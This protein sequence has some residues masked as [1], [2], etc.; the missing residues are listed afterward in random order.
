MNNQEE[1]MDFEEMELGPEKIQELF[2]DVGP[3]VVYD[4]WGENIVFPW[5]TVMIHW[6][7]YRA[8]SRKSDKKGIMELMKGFFSWV[9]TTPPKPNT[10]YWFQTMSPFHKE[11]IRTFGAFYYEEYNNKVVVF[12][13]GPD[14]VIN[15]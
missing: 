13:F 4:D 14:S 7:L 12:Y 2:E 8:F 11:S 5:D 3:A 10:F 6:E 1:K 15:L 9:D